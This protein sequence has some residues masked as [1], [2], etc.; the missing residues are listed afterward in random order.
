MPNFSE[1]LNKIQEMFNK[2]TLIQKVILGVIVLAIIGSI[3]F[4]ANF[5]TKQSYSMLYKSPLSPEE[6]AR[7][8]K[9][10]GEWS[11]K[12]ET[13]DDKFILLKDENQSR[14]IRMRL[15]QEGIIPT[16]VKGWEL[17]DTQKFTTTDFERNVNLQRAI[18]GEMIKHLKSIDDIE[19][20]SIEISF[21]KESLYS[22]YQAPTTAS[23]LIT[24]K[25]YS[26][27]VE[28]KNKVKGI[29]NLVAYGIPNL[30]PEN[31]VV[32]D[33]KGNVLSDLLIPDEGTE[34]L[35]LAREHLKIKE[36]ERAILIARIKDSLKESINSERLILSAD[37]EFDWT[38][39]KSESDKIIPTVVKERDPTL[40]YDNSEVQVNV[41]VSEKKTTEDFQGPA[42]VPEGPA[43]VENNVPPA[44][45]DKMDKFTHYTKNENLVNYQNSKE[46]TQE[47]KAPYEI[48]RVSVA[49]AIDGIWE[50]MRKDD[51]DPII[52][53]GGRIVRT[54]HPVD[55]ES[56][57]NFEEWV[58]AA[59]NYDIR[60][61]DDVVVRTISFDHTKEFEKEDEG[62]RRKIQLRRTLLAS[63]VVLF[64]LF[65]ATLAY[66]AIAREIERRRRLRE[67]EI[68]R[69]QQ[70]MREAAL[71]AAE[72]EAATVE[73]SIE[74]KARAELLE[75]AINISR[76]RPDD[77]ARLIRTWLAEE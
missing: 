16:S 26:D 40:A 59:V 12:F 4:L 20:V 49:V 70:A 61:G 11:V 39:K 77:V 24:P 68:A 43:G 65:L 76:E 55:T 34:A 42:Y 72:E 46:K 52:T 64:F 5:S 10:L 62:I 73:L 3:I 21:P 6:Y 33:N 9:K 8:T 67:E 31:I 35:K 63:I 15:G 47:E 28:N 71:R 54:Y 69:Q 13:K 32:V 51:G 44:L 53:N 75:N 25:P 56:L 66:R 57:R 58:K 41:P 36:R 50:I 27:F 14:T 17:F 22:D 74:E 7:V 2:L 18:I 30:K 38:K 45:K 23:V 1:I 37:I 29:V 48:K 19:D 60:R